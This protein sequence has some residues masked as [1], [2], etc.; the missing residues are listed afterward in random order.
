MPK[1][2]EVINAEIRALNTEKG[3]RTGDNTT[4]DYE[5]LLQS[6][7]GEMTDNY[8]RHRLAT[9]TT[10]AGKPDDVAS[11]AAD[12]FIRTIDMF[13][14]F[15]LNLVA[16]IGGETRIAEMV[17]EEPPA[18]LKTLGDHVNW[19]HKTAAQIDLGDEWAPFNAI[20]FLCALLGVCRKYGIDLEAEYERKM[21]YN[22]RR[23]YQHGGRTMSDVGRV[24]TGNRDG[25][26]S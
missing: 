3:W 15:N 24:T 18:R 21:A 4:G 9:F 6:E 16:L 13:D 10:E 2:I 17:P 20:K 22:R 7:L 5:A 11:E 14:V 8:R 1:T 19:L 12:A 25:L 23:P 26:T